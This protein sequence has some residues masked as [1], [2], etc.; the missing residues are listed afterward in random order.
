MNEGKQQSSTH[1]RSMV[2]LLMIM[3]LLAVFPLDVVLPSFPALADHFR[4]SPSDIAL[5]VSLFAV[6]LAFSL[7][8][9]GPLSDMFG[10]KKLLLSGIALAA[11]GAAG[12][13]FASDYNWFLGF[14]VVQAV[15]CG[16][17]ALSQALV[18]DL[19]VGQELE[20]LRIW[21]ATAGGIFICCSPLMGTWLQLYV[22]WQGSFH[23]FIILAIVVWLRAWFL[24][25]DTRGSSALPRRFFGT[26]WR[27]CS[28]I[29]FLSYWLISALAFACHFSFIVMSPIIFMEHL[30][31]STYE[32]AWTLLIY[33]AAYVIGGV[34]ASVLHR[35]MEGGRQIG[36]G[37]YLIALSGLVM[38]WLVWQ[39]GLSVATVLIPMLICTAG[40]TI[41]RPIA[42]SRAMSLYPQH[43]GT[44]TSAGSL[45]IFMCGGLISSVIN[46]ASEHLTTALALCFLISSAVGLGLNSLTSRRQLSTAI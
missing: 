1:K 29:R 9:I 36:I 37:L 38:L 35:Q 30:N 26:Y 39:F 44:A 43:A 31:L 21:M 41:S 2:T 12:C 6:G 45:L 34:V 33:G 7:L 24:L 25:A 22:G 18:Q 16:S 5:S 14:R 28:D 46:L 40:T 3:T 15:G 4:T 27:L 11:M 32:F 42:N 19:F 20:R 17:F 8:L 10:R 13:L 23:V